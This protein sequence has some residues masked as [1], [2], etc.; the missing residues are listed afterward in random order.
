VGTFCSHLCTVELIS[1]C[2]SELSSTF[3]FFIP[4]KDDQGNDDMFHR[5]EQ[6]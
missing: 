2:S 4:A 1:P 6:W 5:P 3:T